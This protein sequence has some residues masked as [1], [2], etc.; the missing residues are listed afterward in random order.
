MHLNACKICLQCFY[1]YSRDSSN[2][3]MKIQ[4][5][6]VKSV[7]GS[8]N[9]FVSHSIVQITLTSYRTE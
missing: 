5:K 7:K 6:L 4:F 1:L 9:T 3:E 2:P 8:I